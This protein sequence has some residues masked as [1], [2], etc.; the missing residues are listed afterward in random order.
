MA[1][2]LRRYADWASGHDTGSS[3]KA[4]ALHMVGGTCNGAYPL[5]PSDLGRCLRLLDKFPEWRSRL[6]EMARYD[7]IWAAYSE[8]WD[9]LQKLFI[10]EVGSLTPAYGSSAPE[11]YALMK[12]I[13]GRA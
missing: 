6:T 8:R 13:Q 2:I 10:Q 3:S 9:D 4:I 1:D 11:T 7:K 12:S 5:D